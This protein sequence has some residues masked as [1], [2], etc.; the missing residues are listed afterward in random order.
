MYALDQLATH[1]K[2]DRII[3]AGRVDAL[4][5]FFREFVD[6]HYTVLRYRAAEARYLVTGRERG[7]K[8]R[9]F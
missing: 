1:E 2:I 8:R 9:L 5:T 6:S 3:N 4:T 7:S